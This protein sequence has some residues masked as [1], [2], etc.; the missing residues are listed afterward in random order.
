VI[1]PPRGTDVTSFLFVASFAQQEWRIQILRHR[2]HQGQTFFYKRV[3]AGE[4]LANPRR[5]SITGNPPAPLAMAVPDLS[6][7]Q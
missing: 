1:L 6:G 7:G 2:V 4:D 5:R 3:S